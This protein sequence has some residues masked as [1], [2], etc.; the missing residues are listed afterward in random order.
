MFVPK[1]PFF[2]VVNSIIGDDNTKGPVVP[3]IGL[4]FVMRSALKF[5]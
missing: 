1:I 4:V 5:P 2:D 3:F